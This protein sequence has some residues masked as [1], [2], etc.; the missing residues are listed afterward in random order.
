MT[1]K[2]PSIPSVTSGNLAE[3]AKAIKG[4]LDVR[5]GLIGDR[6]DANVTY[7][8]L[9]DA[10]ALVLRPGWNSRLPGGTGQPVIPPW[11]SPDGYDPT[12]DLTPPPKPVDFTATGLF[13]LVQL[14]WAGIDSYRN[15]ASTE[16]WRAESNV[17]GDAVM[18]GTSDGQFYVDSL[19]NS[20]T[21]YYW[22]RFVSQ[23]NVKGPYQSIDGTVA[24]TA[25]NPGLVLAS[26]TN[27]ITESQLYSTLGAR[28]DLIDGPSTL[29]N[30]VA[31]RLAA[32]AAARATAIQQEATSRATAIQQEATAR[33]NAIQQE[34][35]TR[36]QSIL[37][38]AAARA[39]GDSALQSQINLLSAAGSGDFAE[40]LAAIQDE[41]TARAN[42]DAAEAASRQTL[43]AQLRGDYTGTDPSAL[44]TGILYNERVARVSAEGAI[45][46][47]VSSLSA[48]VTNNFN[49]LNSAI[50][51]EQTA[52]ANADTALTSSFN[53]LSAT[54]G[55]KNRTFFQSTTPTATATGDLWFDTG[56]GNKAS[57]WN[58][59][60]WVATDDTR[61][62]GNAAAI[63]AEQT[64]RATA[65]SALTTS[66][67]QLTSTVNTNYT[68]LN[69]AITSEAS[70]RSTADTALSNT[71]STLTSTVNSNNSA[72]T[73]A[74]SNEA[75]ARAGGDTALSS[76]ITALTATVTSNKTSTDAA[77]LT[78]TNARTAADTAIT[79]QVTTLTATLTQANIGRPI[80][81]WTLNG[82]TLVTLTD[83][84]VGKTALRLGTAAGAPNQGY[85][86]PIDRSKKYRTRFWARPVASTNGLLYFSLQQFLDDA[87]TAGPTNGGR[88]PY[89]PSG[90]SR[91]QHNTTYGTDQWGEYSFVW[92]SADWQAG[93]NYVR[94]DFLNN[95]GGTAGYW[96][97]QDFTFTEVTAQEDLAAAIQTETSA[98][99]SADT[100]LTGTITT[101]TATVTGNK[102][103]TDAAIQA[104][105]N[106]R[107]TAIASEATQRN[108][109]SAQLRG[110]YTGTDI[111]QLSSGLLFDER[112]AR[113]AS[114]SAL[115]T[116]ISQVSARLNSGGDIYSSLVTTQNTASAKSANFFQTTTPTATK[117]ND[118]WVDTANGN[119]I[120]RW[121][122]S[123]WVAAE[124]V[125]I[126]ATATSLT[127]VSAR[128]DNAG[129]GVSME[130]RFTAQAGALTGL[131]GQYTVKIDANGYVSGF[132][133]ASTANNAAASSAFSVRADTFYIANPTGP[134]V[135]PAMPFV[136]RTS[137]TTIGGVSVPI[138]VYMTDAFIQNGTISNA[139][140]AN[141]AVDNAKIASL[142]AA[143]ITTGFLSADRIQAGTLDAKI[144]NID[145]AR[146]TSGVI[147][148]ARIGNLDAGKITTGQLTADRI[149]GTDLTINASGVELGK[150][151]GPG[152]GHFGLSLSDTNF[153]NIFLRRS[154]GVAFF[155]VNEG[156]TN[157]ITFD[158]GTGN[159]NI[160]SAGFSVQNGVVGFTGTVI[161]TSNIY[162]E[163]VNIFK[164][165]RGASLPDYVRT[166]KG[167]TTP[168]VTIGSWMPLQLDAAA[169]NN[170]LGAN[171]YDAYRTLLPAGTYFYELSVPVKCDGSDTNDAVYTAI[172]SYPPGTPSG[173]TQTV[174]GYVSTW[175]GTGKDGY[176]SSEYQC[177]QEFVPTTYTVLSTAGV[178]VLGDWQTGTIFGVGRFTLTTPTYV[179]AAVQTTDAGPS[180]RVVARNGYSTTILRI[181]RDG[182]A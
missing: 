175:V 124:D 20:A 32:E 59:T 55:T 168:T 87:G 54:V 43:A 4:I 31:S 53:S 174:C 62:A 13:A 148:S 50:T 49:T 11:S 132:G 84:K 93:V 40:L 92:T 172:I 102:T 88:S 24:T 33:S 70:T 61:I 19:G 30:S 119:L 18:V 120:K 15:H 25:T 86:V 104:E 90:V 167:A 114:D 98:R 28:I 97:I 95:Y 142:D 162:N 85:Y 45:S 66:I 111:S 79:S 177:W 160:K 89:K 157:Y 165:A 107:A 106:A 169:L 133:L 17:I 129:T 72:L 37:D 156:G 73:A 5:E 39:S 51:S 47:T 46:S 96:E 60:A 181:W 115:S 64:A 118:L 12:T 3:V 6:L 153:N 122:G 112:T 131:Q 128:L 105:S 29:V 94:P 141:L 75:T 76:Q 179:A 147:D 182:N 16:I 65:D 135:T 116:S 110:S 48:T 83:G 38:E 58:G 146:I 69:A 52:R 158:S 78:E 99:V 176:W 130:Q 1:T 71:I 67:N 91:A 152:V 2:V 173:T 77:I 125:R 166:Y 170:K 41:Q 56:N 82:Q 74:I 109:L 57:R 163:S 68:S 149:N 134:G 27:Q 136:V 113:V 9:I 123:A 36:A 138:G 14:E 155:R 180:L 154:D 81:Q 126:G 117:I 121:T 139:K 7:R 8:D 150:D 35:T 34:A 23:A 161:D 151:V 144:A 101:L 140:I 103:A 143:K 164:L 21:R 42:A 159:L 22:V 145:A 127:Q 137:A 26:L 100:A 10:G 63:T 108:T 44:T 171:D 178:N 80:Q